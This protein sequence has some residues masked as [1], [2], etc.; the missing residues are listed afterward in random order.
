M[1]KATTKKQTVTST[2]QTPEEKKKALATAIS[3]LEKSYGKGTI[4]KMGENP[5]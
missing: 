3:Q 2:E 5:R 4:I 1:A